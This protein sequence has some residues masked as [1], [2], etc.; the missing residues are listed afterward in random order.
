MAYNKKGESELFYTYEE[1]IDY[2]KR[3]ASLGRRSE[4]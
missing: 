1:R 2:I 3:D 4:S